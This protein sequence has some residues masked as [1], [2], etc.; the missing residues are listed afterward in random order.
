MKTLVA[1]KQGGLDDYQT[2]PEALFILLPYLDPG[3]VV[4]EPAA[5]E[6]YLARALEEDGF[7]VISSDIHRGQNF[8]TY[9]P[10]E[11]Y[12][13]IIT[14]PPYSLKDEFLERAYSLRK[15]FAFLLPLTTLEGK[16][17]QSLFTE[18]GI[19]L[20]IPDK[21][22][23]FITPDGKNSGSWFLTAWFTWQ[24][25]DRDTIQFVTCLR[26]LPEAQIW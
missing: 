10:E 23:N 8:L 24:L 7:R 19:S 5:G 2:P 25:L 4:W 18:N 22:I 12:D 6:G 3:W 9:E 14:N 11:H 21:R 17:R 15:P 16:R 1:Q 13:I 26:Q 20:L